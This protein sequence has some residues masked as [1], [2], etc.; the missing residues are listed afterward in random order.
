MTDHEA[1][2]DLI[3]RYCHMADRAGA[4]ALADLFCADGVLV[5]DGR[6]EG[7]AAV[8]QA[9]ANWI[10]V[11]RDPVAELRHLA[12]LPQIGIDGDEATAE[13]YFDADG[14]SRR[15]LHPIRI[16]GIYRDRLR[17]ER[18]VWRFAEHR[19]DLFSPLE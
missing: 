6:H 5:F 18:G 12:Y 10:A 14:V 3:S 9:F 4:A 7:R 2:R 11:K 13:T 17:K 8:E 16:R 19:I 15:A 1:I